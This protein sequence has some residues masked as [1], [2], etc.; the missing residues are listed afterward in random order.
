MGQL[1]ATQSGIL[2]A[3]RKYKKRRKNKVIHCHHCVY[4]FTFTNLTSLPDLH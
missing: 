1:E 2:D 3:A 4:N